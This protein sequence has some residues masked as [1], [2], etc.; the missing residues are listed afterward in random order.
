MKIYKHKAMSIGFIP[1]DFKSVIEI[2]GLQET[3]F[4]LITF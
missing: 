2:V 1:V 4:V 3:M